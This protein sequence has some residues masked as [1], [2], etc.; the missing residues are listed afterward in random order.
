MPSTPQ[1]A[2]SSH[3][4]SIAEH[5]KCGRAFTKSVHHDQPCLLAG[6]NMKIIPHEKGVQKTSGEGQRDSTGADR[7][8][9][10]GTT[11]RQLLQERDRRQRIPAL[12][13]I[14][15]SIVDLG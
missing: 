6:I 14:R 5:E 8:L 12:A 10:R 1:E 3:F 13:D 7:K 2:S 15:L 4:L 11:T 9:Q